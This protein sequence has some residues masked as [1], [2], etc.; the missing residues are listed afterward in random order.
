MS[1]KKFVVPFTLLLCLAFVF[2]P[3]R[4]AESYPS[5]SNC[6]NKAKSSCED[7]ALAAMLNS[8]EL[9]YSFFN[10]VTCNQ[11]YQLPRHGKSREAA[12]AY[13]SIGFETELATAIVDEYTWII[14]ELNC[15]AIKPCDGL[16][17]I[18][19]D[20]LPHLTCSQINNSNIIFSREF[21]DC[22]FHNDHYLYQVQMKLY[23]D[24]WKVSAINLDK[25]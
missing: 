25:Q 2:I 7:I 20:D 3:F 8:F 11:G 14:P 21:T 9:Y 19:I 22:Y 13:L 4:P 17:I 15:L 6:V 23:K 10:D 1:Y 18:N 5:P 16:P 24:Q 12:I